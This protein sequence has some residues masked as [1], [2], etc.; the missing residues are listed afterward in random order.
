MLNNQK[1]L[2][3][4]AGPMS[5]AI[6]SGIIQS[7][8]IPAQQIYVQNRSNTARL[9]ELQKKYQIHVYNETDVH[10]TEFSI[11]V[12]AVQPKNIEEI[13]NQ[14]KNTIHTNQLIL[15]IVTSMTIDY[16]EE[17]LMKQPIIRV[18][19]NTSSMVC[20]SATAMAVGKFTNNDHIEMSKMIFRSIGEVYTI[21][22][23]HMDIFT[24]IAGSGPAY[25]YAL[26]EQMESVAIE[27]GLPKQ[28]VRSIVA[29]TILGAARMVLG[30]NGSPETLR[31]N[32]AAP[33]GPTEAGLVAL[34]SFGGLKAIKEAVKNTTK[35]SIEIN[36]EIEKSY[37]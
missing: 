16:F 37:I 33:N 28:Q 5:E 22:E 15:S 34:E 21:A 8:V 26:M 11:I 27:G 32:V 13:I 30:N 29:Q 3:I 1:I 20:E 35:R 4:G 24:G 19:P 17:R 2:F 36:E 25:F 10:L 18:M 14:L 7:S 12:L 31:K 6:I 9:K 23:K